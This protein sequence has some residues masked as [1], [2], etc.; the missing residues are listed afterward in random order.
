MSAD[1]YM[2]VAAG[3]A[4]T[5]SVLCAAVALSKRM[6]AEHRK[7]NEATMALLA[8]ANVR[9]ERIALHLARIADS[10]EKRGGAA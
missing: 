5:F 4:F 1:F 10:L 9:R 8:D 6:A 2:G 7:A 3:F